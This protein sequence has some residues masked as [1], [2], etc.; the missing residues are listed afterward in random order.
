MIK[1]SVEICSCFIGICYIK[2]TLTKRF[3]YKRKH[4]IRKKCQT[5]TDNEKVTLNGPLCWNFC[6]LTDDSSR[7]AMAVM[8]FMQQ[9]IY[10]D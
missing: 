2:D 9:C 6:I 7:H 10:E 8:G 3:N 1:N 5:H 4:L